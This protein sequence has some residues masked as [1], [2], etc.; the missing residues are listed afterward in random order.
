MTEPEALPAER[1][2][3]VTTEPQ[4]PA[5]DVTSEPQALASGNNA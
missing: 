4:T 1:A 5:T 2:E 3:D